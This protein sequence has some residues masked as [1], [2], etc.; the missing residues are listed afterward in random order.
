MYSIEDLIMDVLFVFLFG[1]VIIHVVGSFDFHFGERISTQFLFAGII[2]GIVY[3][4]HKVFPNR[5][6]GGEDA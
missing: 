1:A 6:K 5:K 2:A 4:R 3:F